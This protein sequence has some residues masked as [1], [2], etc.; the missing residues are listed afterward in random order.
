MPGGSLQA[1]GPFSP[2]VIHQSI[3]GGGGW[4]G[5]VSDGGVQLGGLSTDDSTGA[6]LNL[7][8]PFEVLTVG[9]NSPGV[10]LQ[11]IGGGGGVVDGTRRRALDARSGV[12]SRTAGRRRPFGDRDEGGDVVRRVDRATRRVK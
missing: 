12:R 3:G 6:D 9:D 10:V 2:G 7:T 1:E 4:I 11:S 5:N 8:L